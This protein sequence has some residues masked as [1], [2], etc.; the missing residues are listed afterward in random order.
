MTLAEKLLPRLSEWRPAGA[1]RHTWAETAGGWAVHLAADK[2]ESLSCLVWELTLA[3]A[4][5]APDGLTVK[6][7]A[8]G[9]ADRVTGLLE[10]LKLYEVDTTRDEAVLRSE[11]PSA[12]GGRL[13]YYEVH[14]FGTTRAVVRRFAADKAVPGREQVAFALTHEVLAKLCGDLAGE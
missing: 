4:G 3:R 8:A 11:A 1:G 14:L 5:D 7:W 13:G 10:P 9:V 6:D 2:A 12:R